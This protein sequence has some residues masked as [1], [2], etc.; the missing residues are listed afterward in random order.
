MGGNQLPP[1]YAYLEQLSMEQLMEIIHADADSTSN[2]NEDFIFAVLEVIE[3]RQKNQ[4]D[5][6]PAD[7]NNAWETFQRYYNTLDGEGLS[8]YPAED[9]DNQ[10]PDPATFHHMRWTV[11]KALA[12]I[13]AAIVMLFAGALTAQA[14]MCLGQLLDGRTRFSILKILLVR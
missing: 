8:L 5:Y 4:P 10:K 1:D 13:A 11:R 6:Q 2:G 9:L 3:K 12:V 7:T 14:L